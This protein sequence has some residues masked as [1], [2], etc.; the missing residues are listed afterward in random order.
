MFRQIHLCHV[1]RNKRIVKNNTSTK[2]E[3]IFSSWMISEEVQNIYHKNQQIVTGLAL[4]Y[5]RRIVIV[6]PK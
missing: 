2:K 5:W 4:A 3:L 6:W 1:N